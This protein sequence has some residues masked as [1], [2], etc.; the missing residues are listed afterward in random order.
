MIKNKDFS[1]V[2]DPWGDYK[3]IAG[4][5]ES[6]LA[7]LNS[8]RQA[9]LFCRFP[10]IEVK[11]KK[12]I[13][14]MGTGLYKRLDPGL[15]RRAHVVISARDVLRDFSILF[16]LMKNF[17]LDLAI[18]ANV[19]KQIINKDKGER[20]LNVKNS[21]GEIKPK[22]LILKSTIDPIN[23]VWA[24]WANTLNIKVVCVQH[25]IFS[26]KADPAIMERDIVDY[27]I[28][29]GI[30]QSEIVSAVIPTHKHINIYD[31]GNFSCDLKNRKNLSICFIGSDYE[32]YSSA[33]RRLKEKV[34]DIYIE[35]INMLQREEDTKYK[36]YYKMH[37]SET[38]KN[39]KILPL[40]EKIKE[41]EY[42]QVDIFFGVASTL[43]VEL[44]SLYKCAIQLRSESLQRDNYEELGY[45]GSIDIKEIKH[46]G[47]NSIMK[48]NRV[49][50]C[51]KVKEIS[52]II[53]SI[54]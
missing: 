29:L 4:V 10:R 16:K 46:R 34:L 40:V 13:V 41:S 54:V 20:F 36:F 49:F 11:R 3:D 30:K 50:P 31:Q 52:E 24:F 8:Y 53:R 25:G 37:P 19:Y 22:V 42:S 6:K 43:I 21:L 7:T 26:S 23:R 45:C 5:Q 2:I 33:G 32:R 47:L 27:Y 38:K 39:N 12:D 51:V 9:L 1:N 14:V 17:T 18:Y 35:V 48:E 15:R 28:T 44:A